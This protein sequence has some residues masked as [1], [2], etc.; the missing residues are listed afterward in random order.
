MK[1][2]LAAFAVS[3]LFAASVRAAPAIPSSANAPSANTPSGPLVLYTS[4]P[5]RI[6]AE[7]AAAFHARYPAVHVRIFR[8]GTTEVMNKLAAE[9]LAGRPQPDVLLIA[10]AMSMQLLKDQGRLLADH[11]VDLS[12]FSP[13]LY[14]PGRTY[15]GTKLITT[16]IIYNT[17]APFVP[18]SWAD[19]LKPAAENEVV[20]P[21]PLYSGAALITAGAFAEYSPLGP[22]FLRDLARAGAIAV[23]GNGAVLSAVAGGQKMFG[24]VVDFMALNA[25]KNGSPVRFVFPT[26]GVTAVTEPVAILKTAHN[27]PAARAFVAFLLSVSGQKLAASQGFLPARR[28]IAP[29]PDYPRT[30]EIHL[31]PMNIPDI[32][33]HR[34]E[35]LKRFAQEFGD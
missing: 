19:L 26:E 8:S 30:G 33:A 11:A 2:W 29:P 10:D 22:G 32:L 5:D 28:G 34:K 6:A 27:I 23:A 24:M 18:R 35:L 16:G 9:F 31:L 20:V 21:N 15:F 3:I 25:E 17:H 1:S 13:A 12:A 4:Q 7:T 14:D